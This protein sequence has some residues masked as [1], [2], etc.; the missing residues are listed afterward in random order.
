VD[1]ITHQHPLASLAIAAALLVAAAPASASTTVGVPGEAPTRSLG[2][3]QT[4]CAFPDVCR[5]AATQTNP[6]TAARGVLYN[7]HAGLGANGL[8]VT[9]IPIR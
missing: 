5:T 7:G 4:T 3:A 9:V 8:N 2:P 6:A 1:R